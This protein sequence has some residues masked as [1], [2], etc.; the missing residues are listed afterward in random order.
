MVLRALKLN[1]LR[2]PRK[3]DEIL[4]CSNL[5]LHGVEGLEAKLTQD[6]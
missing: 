2:Q 4:L 5:T 6:N 3:N 1:K